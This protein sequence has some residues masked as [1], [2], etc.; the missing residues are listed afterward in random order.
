MGAPIAGTDLLGDQ[1]V[2][3]FSI[4]HAQQRFGKAHEGEPLGVGQAKLLKE[5]FHHPL[6]PSRR[7]RR[8]NKVQRTPHRRLAKIVTDRRLFQKLFQQG[9]FID[10]LV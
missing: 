4:R 5:A 6:A 9:F 1:V 10:E 3:G 8:F 2:A 7:P